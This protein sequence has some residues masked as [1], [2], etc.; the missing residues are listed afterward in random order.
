MESRVPSREMTD[1]AMRMSL[2]RFLTM[3]PSR[4]AS[5]GRRDSAIF[6]RFVRLIIQRSGSAPGSKVTLMVS[7]PVDDALEE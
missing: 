1:I 4:R 6:T 5:S 7:S 3:T 2:E